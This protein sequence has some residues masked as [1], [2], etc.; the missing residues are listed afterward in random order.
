[1]INP[2]ICR[3]IH[4]TYHWGFISNLSHP[5][6]VPCGHLTC[7]QPMCKDFFSSCLNIYIISVCLGCKVVPPP[8]LFELYHNLFKMGAFLHDFKPN[9]TPP[10]WNRN[11]LLI[12]YHYNGYYHIF[13]EI[14]FGNCWNLGCTWKQYNFP[15]SSKILSI[16]HILANVKR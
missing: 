8:L 13:L 1:M 5:C 9:F 10:K 16:F 6:R 4:V 14:V 12:D 15:W 11:V 3:T 7:S 2:M